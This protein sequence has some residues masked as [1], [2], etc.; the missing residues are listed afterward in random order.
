MLTFVTAPFVPVRALLKS[1]IELAVET[2]AVRGRGRNVGQ[3]RQLPFEVKRPDSHTPVPEIAGRGL[4]RGTPVGAA[5]IWPGGGDGNLLSSAPEER[6]NRRKRRPVDQ[7][8]NGDVPVTHETNPTTSLPGLRSGTKQ[9]A[10]HATQSSYSAFCRTR[11]E[12][13]L[14]GQIPHDEA[15]ASS[16]HSHIVRMSS[17]LLGSVTASRVLVPS[18]PSR[19]PRVFPDRPV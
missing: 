6:R 15:P 8:V 5:K 9:T 14:G 13:L 19:E 2:P 18:T 10:S 1:P 11:P 7:W 17:V 4:V 16:G 3:T 12:R